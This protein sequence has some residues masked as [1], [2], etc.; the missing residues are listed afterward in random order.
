MTQHNPRP[1]EAYTTELLS[2]SPNERKH[3]VSGEANGKAIE[4]TLTLRFVDGEYDG[5]GW[6]GTLLSDDEA[7]AVLDLFADE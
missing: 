6:E 7:Q 1:G 5:W 3:S 4:G 2:S